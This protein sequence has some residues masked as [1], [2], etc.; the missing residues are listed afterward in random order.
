MWVHNQ[1]VTKNLPMVGESWIQVHVVIQ[2]NPTCYYRVLQIVMGGGSSIIYEH[3]W[4][5][6]YKTYRYRYISFQMPSFS[7]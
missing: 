5:S 7:G 3:H 2:Y 4:T 6:S 1:T